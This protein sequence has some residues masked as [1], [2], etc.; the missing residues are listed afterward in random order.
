MAASGRSSATRRS[1]S[2]G[3]PKCMKRPPLHVPR[4]LMPG[5]MSIILL[6]GSV[7]APTPATGTCAGRRMGACTHPYGPTSRFAGMSMGQLLAQAF[8]LYRQNLR[9][10]ITL[11]LPVVAV[12]I[13]LTALGLGEFSDGYRTALPARDVYVEAAASELVTAPLV[14]S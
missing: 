8:G 12:V 4:A 14:S 2:S 3:S 1:S 10:V 9:L 13:G 11:A 7:H 6:G 5:S